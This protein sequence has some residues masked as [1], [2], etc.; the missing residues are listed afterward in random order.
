M[1]QLVLF[2]KKYHEFSCFL[3]GIYAILSKND[4]LCKTNTVALATPV[5]E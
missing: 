2:K 3:K 5:I 1:H 4:N